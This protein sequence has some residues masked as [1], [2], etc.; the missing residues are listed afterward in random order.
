MYLL[1]QQRLEFNSINKL[2]GSNFGGATTINDKMLI[3]TGEGGTTQHLKVE[4][5]N[6]FAELGM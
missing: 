6:T 3:I 1:M 4:M 2:F 5:A